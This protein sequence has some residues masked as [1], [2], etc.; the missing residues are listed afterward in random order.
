MTELLKK[1]GI[2]YSWTVAT[3]GIFDNVVL[4]QQWTIS[5]SSK[6]NR[7]IGLLREPV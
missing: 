4:R 1:Q 3:Q 6:Q 5:R 2:E 7:L